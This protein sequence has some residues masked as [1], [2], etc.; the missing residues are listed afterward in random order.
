[1]QYTISYTPQQNDI[2][3]GE[4]YTLKEMKNYM[5]Q[6]MGSS[7]HFWVEPINCA[8]Y[9]VNCTLTKA[10]KDITMEQARNTI[11]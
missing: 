9:M 8:N 3:E 6:S 5:I 4:N 10:L 11:K 2:T 7:P 1:M